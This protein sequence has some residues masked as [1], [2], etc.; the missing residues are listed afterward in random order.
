M[1]AQAMIDLSR[2]A[3][4]E[5]T[6]TRCTPCEKHMVLLAPRVEVLLE[7]PNEPMYYLCTKCGRIVQAGVGE[8]CGP[9]DR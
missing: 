4:Q 6:K 1:K 9:E 2:Y 3:A 7:N 8:I 5:A